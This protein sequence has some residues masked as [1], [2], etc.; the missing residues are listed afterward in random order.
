[1]IVP[2]SISGKRKPVPGVGIRYGHGGGAV[3]TMGGYAP[4]RTGRKP[5]KPWGQKGI[6]YLKIAIAIIVIIFLILLYLGLNR[7]FSGR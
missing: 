1:M 7:L 3:P 2:A 6:P 5:R 4:E